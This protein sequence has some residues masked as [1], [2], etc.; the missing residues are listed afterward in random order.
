MLEE[1]KVA[2]RLSLELCITIRRRNL[3]SELGKQTTVATV[4]TNKRVLP[5]QSLGWEILNDLELNVRL[6]TKNRK[7]GTHRIT[8]L[9]A[10]PLIRPLSEWSAKSANNAFTNEPVPLN[11]GTS[12][13]KWSLAC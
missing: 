12:K 9:P 11:A 5:T 4:Y 3:T 1:V 7:I 6:D 13:W 10:I 2:V 8:T